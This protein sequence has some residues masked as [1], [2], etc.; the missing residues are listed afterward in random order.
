MYKYPKSRIERIEAEYPVKVGS[1]D[2]RCDIVVFFDE[3]KP[4]DNILGIIETKKKDEK[5]RVE[6]S[7]LLS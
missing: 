2:K 5:E 1:T 7:M 3:E 6:Q 4:Q